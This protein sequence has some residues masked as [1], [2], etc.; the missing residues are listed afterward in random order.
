MEEKKKK[1]TKEEK[2][3][4]VV[5]KAYEELAEYMDLN[6][7]ITHDIHELVKAGQN[8]QKEICQKADSIK[9][10]DYEAANKIVPISKGTYN[11]FVSV[12][13]R[14]NEGKFTD[15]NV[16]KLDEEFNTK[17]YDVNILNSFLNTYVSDKDLK[18]A[19][20]DDNNF[21]P[22]GEHS[23]E[24]FEKLLQKSASTKSYINTILYPQLKQ[25]AAAAEYITNGEITYKEFKQLNDFEYYK[26]GGY[27]SESTPGRA[28]AIYNNFANAHRLMDKYGFDQS[29]EL[30]NEF[31]L[32]INVVQKNPK[33]HPWML[34]GD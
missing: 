11:E 22:F 20:K 31:G 3:L 30:C 13:V 25:L 10:D 17:L 4:K 28:W 6:G 9:I 21:E 34:A 32:E 8:I 1:E 12:V 27:P 2:R 14:K 26:N 5:K 33:T 15:K 7:D 24:D 23:S 18:L 29:S 16:E 19:N